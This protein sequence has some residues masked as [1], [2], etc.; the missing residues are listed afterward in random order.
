MTTAG[1]ELIE[2]KNKL[3]Q[4]VDS[5]AEQVRLRASESAHL[6]AAL[7][8]ARLLNAAMQARLDAL[9]RIIRDRLN[10]SESS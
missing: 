3:E 10:W 1:D 7:E 4:T 9:E 6:Q 2:A 5:L 8:Q